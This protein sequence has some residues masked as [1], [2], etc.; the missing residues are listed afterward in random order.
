MVSVYIGASLFSKCPNIPKT[1]VAETTQRFISTQSKTGAR[2]TKTLYKT[3][4]K[5]NGMEYVKG[6]ISND[7]Q[8]FL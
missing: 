5:C 4:N 7:K 3:T 1:L 8:L 6:I 2:E